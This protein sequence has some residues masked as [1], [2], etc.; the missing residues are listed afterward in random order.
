MKD[1]HGNGDKE[2]WKRY[3]WKKDL[4]ASENKEVLCCV[5]ETETIFIYYSN[6]NSD[7]LLNFLKKLS[8]KKLKSKM[9][10]TWF[11]MLI[12]Y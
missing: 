8:L 6:V 2:M 4:L 12:E 9:E 1:K 11:Q 5:P 3:I 10:A 7:S